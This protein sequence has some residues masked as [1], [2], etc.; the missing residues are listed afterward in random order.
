MNDP[1]VVEKAAE[2]HTARCAATALALRRMRCD[3]TVCLTQGLFGDGYGLTSRG[4]YMRLRPIKADVP[5]ALRLS[6]LVAGRR[7]DA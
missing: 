1:T 2:A 6:D 3:A 7:V 5:D 4:V